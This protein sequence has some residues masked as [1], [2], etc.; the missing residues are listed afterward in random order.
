MTTRRNSKAGNCCG[1][2]GELIPRLLATLACILLAGCASSAIHS[3]NQPVSLTIS[4]A[5]SLKEPLDAF[6]QNYN[7]QHPD[8]RVVCNYGASGT[9]QQQIEQGA[10]VDIF[11]SAGEKQMDTLQN[12]NLLVAGTRRD[13]I[14]NQL[15]LIAPANSTALHNLNDLAK[16]SVKSI[17]IGEPRTVPAGMYA[18]QVL[19]HLHLL[20]ALKSKIVYA[21]NVR[22]VLAYVETG[23]ASAGLVYSTDARISDRV[24]V[25]AT[26]PSNSH[27]PILYPVAMLKASKS[28]EAAHALLDALESPQSL[29]TFEKYGFTPA[30]AL[31]AVH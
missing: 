21:A 9:L 31:A 2:G 16:L 4:A 6:A 15:V 10:P 23:N 13:L 11:V 29:A 19:E 26:A 22:Q 1:S 30:P 24:R 14:A 28:P 18:Q 12:E 17:A 20:P 7:Q 8:V 5:I 25:V 3:P 27:D